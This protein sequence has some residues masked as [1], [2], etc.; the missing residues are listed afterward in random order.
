MGLFLEDGKLTWPTPRLMFLAKAS[1]YLAIY[2]GQ[3]HYERTSRGNTL[4]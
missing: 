4:S 1:A 3:R 2:R